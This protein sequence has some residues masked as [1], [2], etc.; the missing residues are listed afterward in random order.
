MSFAQPY[1]ALWD[2]G[3]VTAPSTRHMIMLMVLLSF[4]TPTANTEANFRWQRQK[5]FDLVTHSLADSRND[6][7]TACDF[8][9]FSLPTLGIPE[10]YVGFLRRRGS[11]C[12]S[13]IIASHH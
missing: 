11:R 12:A 8:L 6:S 5:E 9:R 10:F 13:R 2:I 1:I 3:S 4:I 7:R